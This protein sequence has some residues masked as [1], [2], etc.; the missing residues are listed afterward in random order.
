MDGFILVYIKLQIVVTFQYFLR[1][2]SAFKKDHIKTSNNYHYGRFQYRFKTRCIGFNKLDEF[3]HLF[4]LTNLIKS[5]F[6][7]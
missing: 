7:Y 4:N 5:D 3:C 6:F 2:I 1:N